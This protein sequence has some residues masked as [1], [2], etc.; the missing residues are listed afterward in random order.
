MGIEAPIQRGSAQWWA[1]VDAHL[2]DIRDRIAEVGFVIQPV[3]SLASDE[4]DFAYTI[5]LT[6]Q[7]RSELVCLGPTCEG[8][9]LLL[10][11]AAQLDTAGDEVTLTAGLSV[12]ALT[13]RLR[14]VA[15]DSVYPL[16]MAARLYGRERVT[17]KQLLWPNDN[18]A[19][20]DDVGWTNDGPAQPLLPPPPGP[21]G[22]G[23]S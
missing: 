20:P 4:V 17:A 5:G 19:Y 1:R 12:P 7:G 15:V 2:A 11:A 8:C 22:G 18:G 16:A 3:F 21:R 13:L 9:G 14:P 6:G 10:S 23:R